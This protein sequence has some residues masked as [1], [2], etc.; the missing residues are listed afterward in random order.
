MNS[1]GLGLDVTGANGQIQ[2]PFGPADY[3]WSVPVRDIANS[4]RAKCA[5]D[6]TPHFG[7]L[8]E[9]EL[10]ECR[11]TGM[12]FWRPGHIAGKEAFYQ[13][14]SS[15]WENYYQQWRWE[16]DLTLMHSKG[17]ERLL[18]VGSGRGHFLKA[19]E[20]LVA[21]AK[22]L[23]LNTQAIADRA[24][25]WDIEPSTI[26]TVARKEP[27]SYDFV[28]SFQV[29][30]HVVDPNEFIEASLGTLRPG[31]K[32][33]ISVPNQAYLPL[34]SDPFDLPPHHMNRFTAESLKKIADHF[35]IQLINIY[36]ESRRLNL[37]D[38]TARPGPAAVRSAIVNSIKRTLNSY[39]AW[40]GQLGQT[41]L[42]IFQR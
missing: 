14:L 37:S 20:G 31:G 12:R 10:Y 17:A 38:T 21:Y 42:A 34:Q 23:E 13:A 11:T 9:I 3:L 8:A 24:T 40:T 25:R 30:E 1:T 19:T 4:Y 7:G 18:E 2:G 27:H 29:L 41:M 26:E 16:Y 15:H 32:L 33:A 6:P 36:E 39:Y 5:Y 28:C 35:G 22:G